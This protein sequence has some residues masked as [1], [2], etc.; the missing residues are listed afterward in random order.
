MSTLSEAVQ[1][2]CTTRW[3]VANAWSCRRSD[4]KWWSTMPSSLAGMH[5]RWSS[6]T[7]GNTRNQCKFGVMLCRAMPLK[8]NLILGATRFHIN[9]YGGNTMDEL[10]E[11]SIILL[12]ASVLASLFQKLRKIFAS[13][14]L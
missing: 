13:N 9:R 3:R 5:Q 4:T 12:Q 7:K 10:I 11:Q 2:N 8:G 1:E 14:R 6:F